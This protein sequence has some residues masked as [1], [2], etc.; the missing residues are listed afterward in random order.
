MLAAALSSLL[1]PLAQASESDDL[2]SVLLMMLGVALF[3]ALLLGVCAAF[4][5]LFGTLFSRDPRS[6]PVGTDSA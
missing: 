5:M 2:F 6:R 1:I 4:E 3:F